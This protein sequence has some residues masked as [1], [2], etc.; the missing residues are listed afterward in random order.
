ML[1]LIIIYCSSLLS[2]LSESRRFKSGLVTVVSPDTASPETHNASV[3]MMIDSTLGTVWLSLERYSDLIVWTGFGFEYLPYDRSNFHNATY[4]IILEYDTVTH[5][6]IVTEW[7]LGKASRG[8]PYKT[9]TLHIHSDITHDNRREV[10]VSRPLEGRFTFPSNPSQLTVM[11]AFH[12]IERAFEHRHQGNDR[13]RNHT[14]I[15]FTLEEEPTVSPTPI[16][17]TPSIAPTSCP[18][19]SI[20]NSAVETAHLILRLTVDCARDVIRLDLLYPKYELIDANWFGL[21]FNDAM[22]GHALVYTTGK[23]SDRLL[24]LYSYNLTSEKTAEGVVY[25]PRHDWTEISDEFDANGLRVIYEQDLSLTPWTVDT[26]LIPFR[27]AIGDALKLN[28]HVFRSD[29]VFTFDFGSKTPTT[30]PTT[31]P[32][33]TPSI[34]PTVICPNGELLHGSVTTHDFIVSITLNCVQNEMKMDVIYAGYEDNWFGLVFNDK[35]HGPAAVYTNGKHGED[36]KLGFH[37]YDISGQNMSQVVFNADKKWNELKTQRYANGTLQVVYNTTLHHTTNYITFRY[38]IGSSLRLEKHIATS[39]D[40]FVIDLIAITTT[41]T[42]TMP[43]VEPTETQCVEGKSSTEDLMIVMKINCDELYGWIHLDIVYFAYDENWFGLVFND[44][45]NGYAAVYTT[46]KNDDRDRALYSYNISDGHAAE[47]VM[48]IAHHRWHQTATNETRNGGLHVGYALQLSNTPWDGDTAQITFRY[49]IGDELKLTQHH[50]TSDTHYIHLR[51]ATTTQP[52]LNVSHHVVCNQSNPCVAD[53]IE[54]TASRGGSCVLRCNDR[55]SCAHVRYTCSPYSSSCRIQCVAAHSCF[56]AELNC[57]ANS[58]C[59][60][61][62]QDIRSLEDAVIHGPDGAELYVNCSD[63]MNG[64]LDSTIDAHSSSE[65][66]IDCRGSKGCSNMNIYCP[67]HSDVKH[68][69]VIGDGYAFDEAPALLH[70]ALMIYAVNSWDDIDLSTYVNVNVQY[71]SRMFC[72]DGFAGDSCH[73]IKAFNTLQW[74][75]MEKDRH[76][77]CYRSIENVHRIRCNQGSDGNCYDTIIDCNE[78][79]RITGIDISQYVDACVIQCNAPYACSHSLIQCF[80][81]KPCS[82]EC[83]GNSSCQYSSIQCPSNAHECNVIGDEMHSLMSANIDSR[84]STLTVQCPGDEACNAAQFKA[85]NASRVSIECGDGSCRDITLECP[86][87]NHCEMSGGG[88]KERHSNLSLYCVN[89]WDD[90]KLGGYVGYMEQNQSNNRMFCED[91]YAENCIIHSL[92]QDSLCE[93]PSVAEEPKQLNW[94]VIISVAIAAFFVILCAIIIACG[95]YEN[96]QRKYTK[97]QHETN[98][99][100]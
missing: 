47:S 9:S 28:Y 92:Q 82:I 63:S 12:W 3:S 70:D 66:I 20:A 2:S 14:T 84:H 43:T 55:F 38:A 81:D 71:G 77:E 21:V 32:S 42:T 44:E 25:S 33:E 100:C 87:I 75:C 4:A 67:P 6:P 29:D 8:T 93:C 58:T 91:D 88:E 24:R 76:S 61:I 98:G 52:P 17:R 59:N 96:Q 94:V 60:V 46:G 15:S 18:H 54:C 1:F 51:E 45:M 68:C 57:G 80:E 10:Q 72:G 5:A 73:I 49:A 7:T 30:D 40:V 16:T 83:N 65:L 13:D 74:K 34:A 26:D 90:I 19:G 22:F 39:D 41:T 27:Y 62:A 79:S 23:K 69:S 11:A 64:C 56:A 37:S 31:H 89:A 53:D 86:S 99:T 35:M 36:L 85:L 95:A 48:Y 50:L 78:T 97:L